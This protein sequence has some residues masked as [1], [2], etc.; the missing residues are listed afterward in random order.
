MKRTALLVPATLLAACGGRTT[1]NPAENLGGAANDAGIY[2][3][4]V[5]VLDAETTKVVVFSDPS[6]PRTHT[7]GSSRGTAGPVPEWS[8]DG[9][10][11]VF[12]VPLD[13]ERFA[14]GIAK[15]P[16]W[17]TI[18]VLP[19][20]FPTRIDRWLG[21]K[22]VMVD[23]DTWQVFDEDGVLIESGAVDFDN[24]EIW[25]SFGSV[26]VPVPSGYAWL[27][28]SRETQWIEL[29]GAADFVPIENGDRLL[30]TVTPLD[31][32][33]E[34]SI[35]N[36]WAI[37]STYV[38][39]CVPSYNQD[40]L[41]RPSVPQFV[42]G[43][44]WAVFGASARGSEGIWS[45]L[46]AAPWGTPLT[47]S[48]ESDDPVVLKAYGSSGWLSDDIFVGQTMW[49]LPVER[50]AK[51]LPL[52]RVDFSLG[53]EAAKVET[54]ETISAA[55][56]YGGSIAQGSELIAQRLENNVPI[57]EYWDLLD[58]NAGNL[59]W[60]ETQ[61][62]GEIGIRASGTGFLS[63]RA[64]RA[65]L[66]RYEVIMCDPCIYGAVADPFD[67]DW[68]AL[69]GTLRHPT[70]LSAVEIRRRTRF[71]P[72]DSGV[73]IVDDGILYYHAFK[74]PNVRFPLAEIGADAAILQPL[75]WGDP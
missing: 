60:Q 49:R 34:I 29:E 43:T 42:P 24:R 7:L 45:A 70:A 39:D 31:R 35:P 33:A 23:D 14:W 11:V 55:S 51:E 47:L 3:R 25:T 50:E 2:F 46:M 62:R 73:L 63:I 59:E 72:D 12:G 58:V 26:I 8:F 56:F 53:L 38:S 22:L 19:V 20:D 67:P 36:L 18:N 21:Q 32:A 1:E 16:E 68:P 74:A 52:E 41:L 64:N 75:N 28:H 13:N 44:D 5:A 71:A 17:N 10:R 15:A 40:C 61:L 9:R 54:T 66:P 57:S 27:H 37:D 4:A 30:M 65:A 69:E 6:Q 48:L